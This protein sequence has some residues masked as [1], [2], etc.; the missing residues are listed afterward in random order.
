LKKETTV[1]TE[2]SKPGEIPVACPEEVYESQSQGLQTRSRNET[3]V[4]Q[5][6]ALSCPSINNQGKRLLAI[7]CL[8]P[9]WQ[10]QPHSKEWGSV[11]NMS[12]T[13]RKFGVRYYHHPKTQSERRQVAAAIEEGVKVR[14]AR[15]EKFLPSYRK[16]IAARKE[17]FR[18]E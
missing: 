7:A 10:I 5:G 18:S 11:C 1:Q 17:V 6:G 14:P 2:G 15:N 3:I 4:T 16:P 8:M 9:L 13:Y 12:R